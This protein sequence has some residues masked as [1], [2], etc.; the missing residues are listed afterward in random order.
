MSDHMSNTVFSSTFKAEL[1][2]LDEVLAF[3]EGALEELECP[4]KC[5]MQ[6]PL[7]I[8]EAF[9][10]VANYAYPQSEGEAE[11]SIEGEGSGV[12]IVLSDSGIPFDPLAK[13]DPDIT[14][15][16]EK[17]NIGGLGIFMVKKIMDKVEYSYTDGKNI[18]TMYKNF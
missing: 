6:I 4:M 16:A 15:S 17:R 13:D 12:K 18:L 5:S 9:V 11:F 10:N 7:A 14:L 1:E 3:L 8:E 2:Q